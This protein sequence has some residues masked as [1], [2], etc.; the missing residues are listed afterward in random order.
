MDLD[1]SQIRRVIIPSVCARESL[2]LLPSQS[3][4]ASSILWC[5]WMYLGCIIHRWCNH[6]MS[7]L[8]ASLHTPSLVINPA[9]FA[10]PYTLGNLVSLSRSQSVPLYILCCDILPSC[11]F[12]LL[13]VSLCHVSRV[14]AAPQRAA[15]GVNLLPLTLITISRLSLGFALAHSF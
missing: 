4:A 8:Q 10:I 11:L 14:S 3:L 6:Q 2:D 15:L 9:K 1:Y 12:P 5:A 7:H 13:S